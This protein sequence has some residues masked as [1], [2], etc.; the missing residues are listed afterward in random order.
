[1]GQTQGAMKGSE[2]GERTR[3][4]D[5]RVVR[6]FISSTF[7]DMGEERKELLKQAF[8]DLQIFCRSRRVFLTWVDMR[9]G[10]PSSREVTR[11]D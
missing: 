11:F 10:M 5:S 7:V 9:W 1:M 3:G 6:V 2:G 4:L 8:A